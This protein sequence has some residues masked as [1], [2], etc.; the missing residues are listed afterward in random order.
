MSINYVVYIV[1]GQYLLGFKMNIFPVWGYES[2]S[3]L[4]LPVLIG[5]ISGLGSNIRFYRTIMLDE[6]YK[7]YV[8]TAYSK[9]H[10]LIF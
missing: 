3:Y 7:D 8:R 2:L 4:I 10:G 5:V 9:K 6:M 1:A